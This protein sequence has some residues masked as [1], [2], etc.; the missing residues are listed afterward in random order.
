LNLSQVKNLNLSFR[1]ANDLRC[2]AEILLPGPEWKCKPCTTVHL[3]K[4]KI[5][6]FYRDPIECLQS[7]MH[8][9]LIKDFINFDPIRVFMTAAKLMR[10]YTEWLSGDTTWSMQVSDIEKILLSLSHILGCRLNYHLAL[11][12]SA[13][14]SRLIR[15]TSPP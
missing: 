8:S 13:Q 1:T 11:P 3:T 4:N 5:N 2:R 9:P 14:F 6:L 12:F 7:L 15:Q 10:V